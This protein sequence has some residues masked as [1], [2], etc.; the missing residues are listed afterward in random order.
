MIEKKNADIRSLNEQTGEMDN[1]S[2][3]VKNLSDQLRRV[4]GENEGLYNE[5]RDSQEKLRLSAT[6]ANKLRTE[7]S[8]F[9]MSSDEMQRK[10]MQLNESSKKNAEYENK[11]AMFSQEIERLNGVV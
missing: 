4:A 5:V 6:E 7:L 10:L 8:D 3:Q 11:I 2:R 1:L 9:K